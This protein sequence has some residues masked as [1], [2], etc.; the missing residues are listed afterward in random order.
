MGSLLIAGDAARL[1]QGYKPCFAVHLASNAPAAEKLQ[2]LE[3]PGDMPPPLAGRTLIIP[4]WLVSLPAAAASPSFPLI[5]VHLGFGDV[6]YFLLGSEKRRRTFQQV[7]DGKAAAAFCLPEAEP[8]AL[9]RMLPARLDADV[10]VRVLAADDSEDMLTIHW[11][12]PEPL[13]G[14]TLRVRR[15][16]LNGVAKATPSDS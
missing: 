7:V 16:V 8:L 14:A 11:T 13:P 3:D 1:P 15:A 9:L 2:R 6:R 10:V 5:A 4:P 12:P